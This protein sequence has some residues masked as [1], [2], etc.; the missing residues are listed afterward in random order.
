MATD[1]WRGQDQNRESAGSRIFDVWAPGAQNRSRRMM[2]SCEF[3][4]QKVTGR[5]KTVRGDW[6]ARARRDCW[7]TG[8]RCE[9]RSG[10]IFPSRGLGV[11]A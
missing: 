7:M 3:Q 10:A 6:L 4:R 5:I 1:F 9:N 8:R 2:C 11:A